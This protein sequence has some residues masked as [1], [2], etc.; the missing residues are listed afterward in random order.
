MKI[1]FRGNGHTNSSSRGN[2]KPDVIVDH[3]VA[4]SGKSCDSWFQSSGNSVSSA[5]FLVWE[6]GTVTQYVDIRRMAWANGTDY[7]KNGLA[8]SSVVKSRRTTNANLYTISIEH[9]GFTGE[10]TKAQL[11]ASIEL[12]KWIKQEVNR[13]YGISIP[14]NR[15]HIIGHFEVDPVRKPSCP[16]PKFP[17]SRII[18][19]ASGG[20]SSAVTNVMMKGDKGPKVKQLQLDLLSLGY[21]LPKYGADSSYGN[22]TVV[23]VKQF[24]KDMGLDIDGVAGPATLTSIASKVKKPESDNIGIVE[25]LSDSLNVRKEA[26]FKSTIVK[27]V[28]KGDKYKVYTE[29]NG[30][31]NLGGNQWCSANSK[32]VK[33]TPVKKPKPESK[34]AMFRVQVGA[35]TDAKNAQN[36]LN[37]LKK[38]KYSPIIVKDG[39][40]NKVQV[41]AFTSKSNADKLVKELKSKAI[42]A[43]IV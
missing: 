20:A 23:T 5:H 18:S 30:L 34:P 19:G 37:V 2:Y 12:H 32:Y 22:E 3:V 33:Y 39:K 14:M 9:A 10:L 28:K 27:V 31:Y 24:Q 4:G 38:L 40:L 36:Q 41:G 7:R 21:L 8:K 15:T 25:I 29:K 1:E 35:Y 13:I 26:N 43:I 11:A 6:D 17:W 42:N 16:G